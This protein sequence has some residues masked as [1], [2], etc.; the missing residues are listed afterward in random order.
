M[1]LLLDQDVYASTARF[2]TKRGHDVVR[3]AQ[4]GLSQASDQ[5]LLTT[6]QEQDRILITRDR[7][8]GA[9][10]FVNALGAGVLYLRMLPST[11]DSVHNELARVLQSYSAEEL[12]RAFVV[13]EPDGHRFRRLPNR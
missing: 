6:A 9:L 11:Q 5:R 7:D 10:V 2:L 13:I 3:V 8:F 1:R 4:F 12:K